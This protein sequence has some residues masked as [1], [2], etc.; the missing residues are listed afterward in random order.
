MQRIAELAEEA[1]VHHVG[2]C[3]WFRIVV[4]VEDESRVAREAGVLDYRMCSVPRTFATGKRGCGILAID[5]RTLLSVSVARHEISKKLFKLVHCRI[6][7][8][9]A[10]DEGLALVKHVGDQKRFQRC[11]I[12]CRLC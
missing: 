12:A 2:G 11:K 10:R 9:V 1:V 6:L 8:D 3:C 5:C 7:R 4:R